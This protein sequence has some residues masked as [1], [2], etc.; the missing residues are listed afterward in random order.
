MVFAGSLMSFVKKKHLNFFRIKNFSAVV[1]VAYG[2]V[3]WHQQ[4][5]YFKLNTK[6]KEQLSHPQ[7]FTATILE[8]KHLLKPYK[9]KEL[10]IESLRFLTSE[11][12]V[13]VFA[14]VIMS[15]HLQ[16]KWKVQEG[17]RKENVQRDFLK[18]TGQRI[19]ADLLRNHPKVLPQFV[20][21]AKDR[22]YQFWERSSLSVDLFSEAV[23]LQKLEYVHSNP[24][25]A[26]LYEYP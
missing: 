15:N 18:F 12:R 2:N 6:V 10:I 19:K 20:V 11:K 24:V 23:F 9:Y 17:H 26:G 3:R 8:W 21:D 13:E 14:F 4:Q 16:L 5:Q 25:R 1:A 22:K 7:F